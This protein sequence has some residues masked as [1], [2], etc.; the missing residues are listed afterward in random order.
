MTQTTVIIAAWIIQVAIMA[1]FDTRKSGLNKALN[2]SALL[3]S[4]FLTYMWGGFIWLA[5]PIAALPILG[6]VFGGIGWGLYMKRMRKD[7]LGGKS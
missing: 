6:G 1:I 2:L 5:V 4:A 3:T 7:D